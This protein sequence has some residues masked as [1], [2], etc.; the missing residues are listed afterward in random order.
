M[1]HIISTDL[2]S[3]GQRNGVAAAPPAEMTSSASSIGVSCGCCAWSASEDAPPESARRTGSE[4]AAT[5]SDDTAGAVES[6]ASSPVGTVRTACATPPMGVVG[7]PAI[8]MLSVACGSGIDSPHE[9]ALLNLASEVFS[10]DT[11]ICGAARRPT[12]AF[13]QACVALSAGRVGAKPAL[14]ASHS[15]QI[16]AQRS[17]RMVPAHVHFQ[18]LTHAPPTDVRWRKKE[19]DRTKRTLTI[20]IIHLDSNIIALEPPAKLSCNVFCFLLPFLCERNISSSMITR[21]PPLRRRL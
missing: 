10:S 7:K 6:V 13:S 12:R 4:S 20:T 11:A 19:E 8:A 1:C 5:A 18:M 21:L 17:D 14:G 3:H 15:R 9:C 2:M 16:R